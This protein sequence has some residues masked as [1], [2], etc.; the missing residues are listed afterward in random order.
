MDSGFFIIVTNA[1]MQHPVGYKLLPNGVYEVAS[2]TQLLLNPGPGSVRAQHV[3]CRRHRIFCHGRRRCAL[4]A[5]TPRRSLRPYIG[6]MTN[7]AL[8]QQHPESARRI[9]QVVA[10]G[11]NFRGFG[12]EMPRTNTISPAIRWLCKSVPEIG[13]PV[14][15]VG[16]NVTVQTRMTRADVDELAALGG[17]LANDLAEMHRASGWTG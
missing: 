4:R 12:P 13:L 17:P 1:W 10:M 6:A 14:M 8:A 15:L 2:F 5:P 16:L 9:G 7:L 3:R 11:A